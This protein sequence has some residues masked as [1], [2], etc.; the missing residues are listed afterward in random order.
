MSYVNVF[1]EDTLFAITSYLQ[2]DL[3][4][5]PSETVI[6][7]DPFKY[8]SIYEV[9]LEQLEVVLI[10]ALEKSVLNIGNDTFPHF[11]MFILKLKSFI[12]LPKLMCYCG[13]FSSY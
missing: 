12:C 10:V 8:V 1:L 2:L 4:V 13:L 3:C 11:Y 7:W 6:S 9:L 5:Y